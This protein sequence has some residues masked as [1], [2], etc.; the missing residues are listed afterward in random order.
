MS[1]SLAA[2]AVSATACG[3][4]NSTS[5]QKGN[6][7]QP[8]SGGS[9]GQHGSTDTFREA[10]R[11]V[12]HLN[13]AFGGGGSPQA[14]LMAAMMWEGLVRRDP[15]NTANYLP[16]VAD[17][18]TASSDGLTHTFH[19]RDGSKWSNGEP[20]TAD[21]FV[22]SYQY[23][24][25]PD[26]A[27]Q[28][29]GKYPVSHQGDPANTTIKGLTDY[30]SGESKDFAA[31]GIKATDKQTLV[32][33]LA[34][35]SYKFLDST[36]RDSYPLYRKAVEAKPKDFWLAENFVGNGPYKLTQYKQ[37]GN[38][39]L[40]LNEHYWDT[41]G[42]TITKREIQF[43]SSGSTGMMVSYNAD[44]IDLFRVD[45]DPTALIAGRKDLE[46]Q[47]QH[48]AYVQFKGLSVMPSANALLQDSVK[49][50]RALAMAVDREALATVS[51]PDI[52]GPSWVPSG[53]EGADQ[54]PKIPFDP[55]K[56]KQLLADAG[57]PD[58][59]GVPTLT[60]LT[61]A[62]MPVL[63][64]VTS[65]W[66]EHLGIKANVAVKEVGVYSDMLHGNVPK[67]FVGFAFNYQAPSPF[68]MMRYGGSPYFQ[69]YAVPYETKKKM[70]D[71]QYGKDKSKYSASQQT[72]MLKDLMEE[73]WL[74]DYKHFND[75]VQK[76]LGAQSDLK[77]A[78]QL[79]TEA[80]KVFQETYLW[81]PLLW[82]G[83]TFMVKPHVQNL[84]LTSY[85]D[86]MFTLKD[87]T[88]ET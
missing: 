82:A 27:K 46:K 74:P 47:L 54:L 55:D 79:A 59:K 78:G 6:S 68:M 14:T 17:T 10:H 45:G 12:N 13:P 7:S 71:I 3:F 88:F 42:F 4:N 48:G 26:L 72:Q 77:K 64:A 76:A 44:E 15:T 61:Y 37:N 87:V 1:I 60:I 25:S 8:S 23:Y 5:P 52:A 24:Y 19:L 35:P 53:I 11:P 63:E 81:M 75:L 16:G 49:L 40:E 84:A 67:D 36:V 20:L 39:T 56:A 21:D 43:N 28:S 69:D 30:F 66:K 31:V 86:D 34:E 33:T 62:T 2:A 58:G 73:N 70:Y 29:G 9:G 38:A 57:H 32:F 83:Y 80:A 85:P 22:W 65:M 41:K 50:R 51:P 18:W